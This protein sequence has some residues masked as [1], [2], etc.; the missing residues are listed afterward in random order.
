MKKLIILCALCVS[1]LS[2][3]AQKQDITLE[4]IFSKG[5]F[6][7]KGVAGFT[8][9]KDGKS[10]CAQDENENMI[11][12]SIETGKIIDTLVKKSELTLINGDKP[13]TGF[14]F[15]W[16]NDENKLLLETDFKHGYRHSYKAVFYVYDLMARKLMKPLNE[17][18]MLANFS[19]DASKVAYTKDN[20]LFYFDLGSNKE[21]Q[22]TNDGKIN[23]IINGS[24]DLSLIHI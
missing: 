10:Y 1:A 12:Y 16:S 18:V 19:P 4:D 15:K 8:S 7:S 5:T 13:L 9:M 24:T 23:N 21:I 6:A 20:N 14:S 22:I 17:A 2:N 3:Y 11:R